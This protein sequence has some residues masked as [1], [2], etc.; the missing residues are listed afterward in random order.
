[1]GREVPEHVKRKIIK[2]F[3][4]TSVPRILKEQEEANEK[5]SVTNIRRTKESI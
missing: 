4:K 1:M 2:F 3:L 5:K